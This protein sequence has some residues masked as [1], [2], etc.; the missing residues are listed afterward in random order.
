MGEPTSER[1]ETRRLQVGLGGLA[2]WVVGAA[3]FFALARGARGFWM[4]WVATV[5]KRPMLDVD[6]AV[7]VALLAPVTLIGL[8]LLLDAIRP[9]RRGRAFATAWRL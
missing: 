6:R 1:A 9:D 5:P 2:L 4:D 3:V 7:G 8:R